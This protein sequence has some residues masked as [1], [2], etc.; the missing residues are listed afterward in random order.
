MNFAFRVDASF[1]IGTG[2][3]MRCLA[4]ADELVQRG[5]A[6]TFICRALPGNMLEMIGE[7]GHAVIA[8]PW[9][10]I[11]HQA[12]HQPAT[13]PAHA[14]W[15]GCGWRED[16]AE[17]RAALE[18]L[19]P[20]WL[21]VDH[22]ALD[23]EWERAVRT[24][25]LRLMVIDDLHD[26]THE[27]DLLLDQNLGASAA[28]YAVLLA[29]PTMTLLGPRFALLR[30]EFAAAGH[31]S[32]RE[33]AHSNWLA[34][35]GGTDPHG[36]LPKILNAW[37][38]ID[39]PKPTL[40]VAVRPDTPNLSLLKAQIAGIHGVT[41]HA[42]AKNFAALLRDSDM[43]I[44]AAGTLNWERCCVGRP[45]LL[46]MLAENQRGLL[47]ALTRSRT[48]VSVGRWQDA[49]VDSIAS[50]CRRLIA[51]P[52]LL[53]A[54]ARRARRV[55]DG[56][57]TARVTA[58]LLRDELSLRPAAE[59]DADLALTWRN[60]PSTRLRS[61]VSSAIAESDHRDWWRAALG[62]VSRTLLVAT[63]GGAPVGVLRLDH[64]GDDATVSIYLDPDLTGL[65]VGTVMLRRTA[66]WCQ[67]RLPE[68][69][70]LHAEILPENKA[71]Q[72]AF[73]KAGFVAH[74]TR[75]TLHLT[76]GVNP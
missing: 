20:R 62:M 42:P 55:V 29:R 48:G 59:A 50:L 47:A 69:R 33:S 32:V 9:P 75:W 15:L 26:R 37:S 4:L 64:A 22:Y 74:G 16:A 35:V 10:A 39:T 13:A 53:R 24:G 43:V 12:T 45:A 40:D 27:C 36:L 65:G 46:G 51:R 2:H 30:A 54:M 7:S 66:T 31:A 5:G 58:A 34:C 76:L 56:K 21:V 19:T 60:A 73:H 44:C 11:P 70:R 38:Q 67:A 1:E 6:C 41:L 18:G 61:F 23:R 68:L 25:G 8:L 71:S 63:L 17:T 28:D 14:G 72:A 3:V 49:S 52:A 57:G